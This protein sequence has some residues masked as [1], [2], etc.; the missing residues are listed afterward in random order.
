MTLCYLAERNYYPSHREMLSLLPTPSLSSPSLPTPLY[1]H[2]PLPNIISSTHAAAELPFVSRP[3]FHPALSS[4][5]P[6]IMFGP[7]LPLHCSQIRKS[8]KKSW[9]LTYQSPSASLREQPG[10]TG[11]NSEVASEQLLPLLSTLD[12]SQNKTT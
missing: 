7:F 1:H 8:S 10:I 3:A 12:P 6:V 5:P 2:T 11:V 9:A 4:S